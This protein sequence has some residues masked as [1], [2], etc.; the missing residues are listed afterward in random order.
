MAIKATT[1]VSDSLNLDGK[2]SG[3]Y[4]SAFLKFRGGT[5][6][7]PSGTDYALMAQ[8][9]MINTANLSYTWDDRDFVIPQGFNFVRF[10][11]G[12]YGIGG[13]T[14]TPVN[15]GFVTCHCALNGVTEGALVETSLANNGKLTFCNTSSPGI[16][17]DCFTGPC[18]LEVQPGDRI[19]F[20]VRC[21][22]NS[23]YIYSKLFSIE[24][25]QV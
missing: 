20:R 12:M 9:E 16:T 10:W 18:L 7:L 22:Q 1:P 15:F 21:S 24:L 25:M 19:G 13:T 2:P 11:G 23:F 6:G 17:H 5:T 8:T 4:K 3:V 14:T